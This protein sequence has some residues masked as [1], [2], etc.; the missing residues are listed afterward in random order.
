[1]SKR[2]N[3]KNPR[4]DDRI[5][6]KRRQ[7]KGMPY[8]LVSSISSKFGYV[9]A[10]QSYHVSPPSRDLPEEVGAGPSMKQYTYAKGQHRNDVGSSILGA[11]YMTVNSMVYDVGHG[12]YR[13]GPGG[14]SPTYEQCRAIV[15]REFQDRFRVQFD[16]QW[17]IDVVNSGIIADYILAATALNIGL[18]S[19]MWTNVLLSG[20]IAEGTPYIP[21]ASNDDN[22]GAGRYVSRLG[23]EHA[24]KHLK[25]RISEERNFVKQGM[26]NVAFRP[27]V[28]MYFDSRRIFRINDG[29]Y[30]VGGISIEDRYFAVGDTVF[31][32]LPRKDDDQIYYT[33]DN[34]VDFLERIA[35]TLSPIWNSIEDVV[36]HLVTKMP[37]FSS[38]EYLAGVDKSTDSVPH[39]ACTSFLSSMPIMIYGHTD[40]LKRIK[41]NEH[42]Y[43]NDMTAAW[44]F[45]FGHP[46]RYD[47]YPNILAYPVD[48]TD[49]R[50]CIFYAIQ[51]NF[52]I[53]ETGAYNE[54]DLLQDTTSLGVIFYPHR[55]RDGTM[56]LE[57]RYTCRTLWEENAQG[58]SYLLPKPLDA[59]FRIM[60]EGD[61]EWDGLD[62]QILYDAMCMS[63][64]DFMY[65]TFEYQTVRLYEAYPEWI[66]NYCKGVGQYKC[67]NYPTLPLM[68]VRPVQAEDRNERRNRAGKRRYNPKQRNRP[69]SDNST[70]A[71]DVPTSK[72]AELVKPVDK[73]SDAAGKPNNV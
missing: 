25:D 73:S 34:I 9:Y 33:L 11:V 63:Y 23:M 22:I 7:E 58:Y 4:S 20:A 2:Y 21:T 41:V 71:K 15:Q 61:Y 26:H 48:G 57:P 65:G 38:F 16:D 53:C 52:S 42:G 67:M 40:S 29:F 35:L 68:S 5:Q 72:I 62:N 27:F 69:K 28:E 1:M 59:V 30:G 18:H 6:E 60:H 66:H 70:L 36:K 55:P 51:N 31:A 10:S 50:F 17:K 39:D 46:F 32:I 14:N 24:I 3:G 19:F 49:N 45:W 56:A 64:P 44:F 47:W 13:T 37:D 54:D 12:D 43:P 8:K